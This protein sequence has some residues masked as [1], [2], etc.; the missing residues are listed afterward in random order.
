MEPE[1]KRSQNEIKQRNTHLYFQGI[2]T[3]SITE[4]S[5]GTTTRNTV[6]WVEGTEVNYAAAHKGGGRTKEP[7]PG[8]HNRKPDHDEF[9]AYLYDSHLVNASDSGAAHQTSL[10]FMIVASS[11]LIEAFIISI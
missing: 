7:M 11:L 4:P 5:G 2:S 3:A 8:P 6:P 1:R 9:D 10:L